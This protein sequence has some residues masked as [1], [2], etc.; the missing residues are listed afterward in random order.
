MGDRRQAREL[1]LKLLYQID[2]AKMHVDTALTRFFEAFDAGEPLDPPPAFTGEVGTPEVWSAAVRA[3]AEQ[4]V[5]G[6]VVHQAE[7]DEVIQA[8]STHWRLERMAR[9]DR[10]L[11]RLG[12]FELLHLPDDV[13]RKVVINEAVEIAKLYGTQESSAFVNGVLDRIGRGKDR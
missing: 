10:N 13:P 6:V 8:V 9:V 3:Y 11:I 7:L 1:A 12:A 5:R 2:V 4:L